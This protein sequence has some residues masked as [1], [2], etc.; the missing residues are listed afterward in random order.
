MTIPQIIFVV[1]SAVVFVFIIGLLLYKPVRRHIY[2]KNFSNIYGKTLYQVALDY[3]FYIINDLALA[4]DNENIMHIDHI[5]FGDKYIYVIRDRY[6]D[7]S[8]EANE[9]DNSWIFT[10]RK[11][12]RK[13]YVDNPL[14]NN[15]LRTNKLALISGFDR[16]LFIS[17]V[18]INDGCLATSFA[19]KSKVSFLVTKNKVKKLI[20]ALESR[21][22][23]KL[24]ENQ[25]KFAVKDIAKLNLN[26]K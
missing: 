7:G 2:R 12:K 23:S 22:I 8:I 24:K 25:L 14:K 10:S 1:A 3:D 20:K 4:L 26:K 17:I 6:Y 19:G 5:L 15:I 9:D 18:V 13:I 21:N 16:N 11:D